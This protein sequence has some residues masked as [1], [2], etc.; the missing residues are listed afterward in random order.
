MLHIRAAAGGEEI[1]TIHSL[2]LRIKAGGRPILKPMLR[3]EAGDIQT[4]ILNTP[5]LTVKT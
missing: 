1:L 2:V 5:Y 4:L 3:I